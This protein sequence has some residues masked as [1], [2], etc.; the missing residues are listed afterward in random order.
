MNGFVTVTSRR[1]RCMPLARGCRVTYIQPSRRLP[2]A[3]HNTKLAT[4]DYQ[5]RVH[6]YFLQF[7]Q[8]TPLVKK[9]SCTDLDFFTLTPNSRVSPSN[10]SSLSSP[11]S[12]LLSYRYMGPSFT[13]CVGRSIASHKAD[14]EIQEVRHSSCRQSQRILDLRVRRRRP[15]KPSVPII[16]FPVGLSP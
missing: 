11:S 4:T 3:A 7:T 12:Q 15:F 9:R 8:F 14:F 2:V 6:R 1:R 13:A 10:S 16:H 5:T